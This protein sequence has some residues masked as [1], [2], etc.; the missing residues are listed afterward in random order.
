MT[1]Q[2]IIRVLISKLGLDGHD[3]GAK[4][5]ARSLRDAGMEVIYT[6]RRRSP[7]DIARIAI[8]ED[9]DVVGISILSGA[10][11]SLMPELCQLLKENNAGDIAVIAGGII[12]KDDIPNLKQ[13]GIKAVFGPGTTTEEIIK[14]IRE[15]SS[16][17]ING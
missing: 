5:I 4:L 7:R 9:V 1:A 12:P 8:E 3:R 14:C 11:D 10:H 6:G 17:T 16:N 2:K 13:A 15:L